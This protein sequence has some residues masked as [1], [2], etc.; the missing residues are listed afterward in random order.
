MD[1]EIEKRLKK[2]EKEITDLKKMLVLIQ[3][4]NTKLSAGYNRNA[5]KIRMLQ[6]LVNGLTSKL[7]RMQ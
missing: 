4:Q 6:G 1:K 7:G 5:D 3:R 2:Q